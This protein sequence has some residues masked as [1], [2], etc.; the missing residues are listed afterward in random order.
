MGGIGCIHL[1]L[2]Q[3]GGGTIGGRWNQL[4]EMRKKFWSDAG[5]FR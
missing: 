2:A 5:A 1:G 4:K 3:G